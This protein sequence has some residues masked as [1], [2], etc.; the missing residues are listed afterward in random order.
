MKF[1]VTKETRKEDKKFLVRVV[2]IA[3]LHNQELWVAK[4]SKGLLSMP[5]RDLALA[6]R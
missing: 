3:T 2:V 1:K 5:V 6:I 4:F